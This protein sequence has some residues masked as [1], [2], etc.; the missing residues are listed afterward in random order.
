[1]HPSCNLLSISFIVSV[2][3]AGPLVGL[4]PSSV[5]QTYYFHKS[6][7]KRRDGEPPSHYYPEGE[8]HI[9]KGTSPNKILLR[10]VL[11]REEDYTC[12][13]AAAFGA[14]IVS[15]GNCTASCSGIACATG[16]VLKKEKKK[17]YPSPN[18]DFSSTTREIEK[19][20]SNPDPHLSST[21]QETKKRDPEVGPLPSTADLTC[22]EYVKRKDK[23]SDEALFSREDFFPAGTS[24]N[25]VLPREILKRE[26]DYDC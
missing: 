1:M 2:G 19:R 24:P 18:P 20:D 3:L 25:R 23:R 22:C 21:A 4:L 7:L 5:D 12:A 6:K 8:H 13:C 9:P 17:R 15:C 14:C 16:C 26:E 10:D 11:K